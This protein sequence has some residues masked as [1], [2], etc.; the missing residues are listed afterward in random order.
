MIPTKMFITPLLILSQS[1]FAQVGQG[2]DLKGN[3]LKFPIE[4]KVIEDEF[5][6][7]EEFYTLSQDYLEVKSAFSKMFSSSISKFG[8]FVKGDAKGNFSD[9]VAVSAYSKALI[10]VRN[11]K[12]KLDFE[13]SI[14]VR[15][16]VDKYLDAPWTTEAPNLSYSEAAYIRNLGLIAFSPES[17]NTTSLANSLD[18]VAHEIAHLVVAQ[19]SKLDP[20][21]G[22]QAINE[23][24]GDI[25]GIYME[26]LEFPETWNWKIGDES[27]KDRV[28]FHRDI[29]DIND[30]RVLRHKKD[31]S[32]ERAHALSGIVSTSF[33]YIVTGKDLED[34]VVMEASDMG[35]VVKLYLDVI[36]KD[37]RPRTNF[38]KLKAALLLRA[39]VGMVPKIEKAFDM[40]GM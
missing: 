25:I 14:P 24:F 37:L 35:K 17:K 36:T 39:E 18:I 27:Y 30:P 32:A 22:S 12:E 29:Q 15:I 11:L 21:I 16:V 19:T 9:S 10:T 33:Y 23:A 13:F 5:F 7:A 4:K 8:G 31:F 38:T 1:V 3:S 26:Y 28:S 20:S 2:I 6:G 40:V 34:N